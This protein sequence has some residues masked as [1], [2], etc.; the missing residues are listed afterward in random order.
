MILTRIRSNR[1]SR[2]MNLRNCSLNSD[3]R[4]LNLS[5][6]F[7]SQMMS[8]LIKNQQNAI[9][10]DLANISHRLLIWILFSIMTRSIRISLSFSFSFSISSLNSKRLIIRHFLN[11][12]FSDKR[13]R[14]NWLKKVFSISKSNRRILEYSY[15]QF[16]ICRWDKAS[17]H[18]QSVWKI[19]SRSS[20]FQWSK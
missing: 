16:S 3:A 2:S 1:C 10:I 4:S 20:D 8:R 5:R 19:S 7:L 12:L 6:L 15:I 9:A 13:K 14:S 18:W 11:L 17:Q